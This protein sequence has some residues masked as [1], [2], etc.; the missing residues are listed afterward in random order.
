MRFVLVDRILE[1]VPGERCVGTRRIPEDEELFADHFPGF[2]VMPGVLLTEMM[3]Q[4]AAKALD[5][6][7][8]PRG[9][10]LLAKILSASF[11]DWVRPGSEC[12]MTGEIS[13]NEARYAHADCRLEV[14][15]RSV[16]QCKLMFTFM[17]VE[18]FAPQFRD[19]VLERFLAGDETP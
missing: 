1:L 10:A 19:E 13:A 5:A 9:K 3:G 18:R 8:L 7:R 17:P 6:Q 15:G 14:A 12:T 11:R 2:P 4:T 16:A